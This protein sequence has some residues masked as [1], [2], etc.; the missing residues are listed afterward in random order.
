MTEA[1]IAAV[2]RSPI[3]RAGKGSLRT[4]RPDDL[5]TQVVRA[6]LD[7]VPELKQRYKDEEDTRAVL[8]LALELEGVTRGVG[9]HAGG[10]VIAPRPLTDFAPLYCEPGGAGLRTQF[11]RW[12]PEA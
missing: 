8:D 3:G 12:L 1:V 10:V 4:M 2:A 6:V 9:V 7:S 11:M 5:A